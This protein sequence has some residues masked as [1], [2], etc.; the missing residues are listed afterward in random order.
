MPIGVRPA[1]DANSADGAELLSDGDTDAVRVSRDMESIF[2]PVTPAGRRRKEHETDA[3]GPIVPHDDVDERLPS[4]GA[5][6]RWSPGKPMAAIC[7]AMVACGVTW[8]A[9][10]SPRIL[11][12][13]PSEKVEAA[14]QPLRPSPQPAAVPVRAAASPTA[15]LAAPKSAPGKDAAAGGSTVKP[16]K[17]SASAAIPPKPEH[18]AARKTRPQA[19]APRAGA[20]CSRLGGANLAR[21][22][23]PE[24]LAADQHLR[25][26][27]AAAIRAGVDRKTLSTYR[28]HWSRIRKKANSDPVYVTV[29]FRQMA[30]QLDA[31]RTEL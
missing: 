3:I 23:R 29:S 22:M 13:L 10:P 16:Q 2:G 24:I 19:A 15:G 11:P 21:C 30:R 27:Y 28:K 7:G 31:A 18:G 17:P 9:W 25:D 4:P 6:R 20:N 12:G 1:G 5:G 26:A 8:M 14:R